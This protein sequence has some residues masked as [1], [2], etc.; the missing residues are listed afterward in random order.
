MARSV[1]KWRHEQRHPCSSGSRHARLRRGQRR[2]R[3]AR[4]F[5]RASAASGRCGARASVV[6]FAVT[7]GLEPHDGRPGRRPHRHHGRRG[8]GR[9]ERD[10]R[11]QPGPHRRVVLGRHPQP[12]RGAARRSR[13][14]RR[15]RVPR[16][17]ARRA[18]WVS[19]SSP[20]APSRHR[21]GPA[22]AA[23]H[24]ASRSASPA[25]TV[26]QGDVVLADETGVVVVPRERAD[27]V[28]E[29]ATAVV[30]RERA[31]ADEVRA[32]R[33]PVRGHARRPAGRTSQE[34]TR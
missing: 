2:A 31:I 32:G 3:P 33:P 34:R 19:R 28:A 25:L 27:E 13:R 12:G 22:A 23:V 17:G 1:L 11:G 9:P 29:L 5:R 15:R 7:V 18:S 6:G 20:A 24:R 26:H 16:R 8:R 14:R 21:A 4:T 10:R 30:A